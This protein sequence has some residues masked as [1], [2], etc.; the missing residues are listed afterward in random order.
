MSTSSSSRKAPKLS[1]ARSLEKNDG[2]GRAA[3]QRSEAIPYQMTPKKLGV[4][5]ELGTEEFFEE[6]VSGRR[7][8]TPSASL[9]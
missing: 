1:S 8:A 3:I 7:R 5:S 2:P 6:T 4:E 9:S